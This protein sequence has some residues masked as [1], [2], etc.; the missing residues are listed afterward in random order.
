MTE[1]I[2][3]SFEFA[4]HFGKPVVADFTGPITT[5]DGG[6]LL[7]RQTDARIKLM[8]RFAACFQD[9]R[10]ARFIQHEVAEMISQCVYGIALEWHDARCCPPGAV[11]ITLSKDPRRSDRPGAMAYTELGVN[12]HIVVFF[13]RVR[14]TVG[15]K[16]VNRLLAYVLV[17]EITHL[18]QGVAR[19]SATGVMKARWDWHDLAAITTRNLAFE[20]GDVELIRLGLAKWD[21]RLLASR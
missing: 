18:L 19:H 4:E 8:E 2:Q 9:G 3:S 17:H 1:C 6:G 12:R 15:P 7:L 10:D 21:G 14:D 11:R 20:P 16:S 5:S 13:D